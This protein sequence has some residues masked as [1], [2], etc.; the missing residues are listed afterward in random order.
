LEKEPQR[1]EKIRRELAKLARD[2]ATLRK[3]H[4]EVQAYLDAALLIL[5]GGQG[6]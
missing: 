6:H 1:P 3:L 2:A 4:P 5:A